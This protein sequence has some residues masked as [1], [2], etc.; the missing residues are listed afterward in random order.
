MARAKHLHSAA[1]SHQFLYLLHV[2]GSME[3][4]GAIPVVTC[5]VSI[6]FHIFTLLAGLIQI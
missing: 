3:F 6:I 2:I 1:A 5:P 4:R